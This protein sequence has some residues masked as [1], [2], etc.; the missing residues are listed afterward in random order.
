VILDTS[1]VV[2][3]L[4][5]EHGHESLLEHLAPH[6]APGIGAPT[7]CEAGAVLTTRLGV[8]ARTLL[9][10]FVE[11]AGIVVIPFG[12]EHWP[13]AVDAFRRF[14]KGRHEARLNFGDCLTYATA[15][16]ADE[17]LLALGDDFAKT[18]LELV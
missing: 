15:R 4:L 9:A 14:G 5:R 18:D 17:P 16:L 3:I 2:S 7:L 12:D 8:Q 10:R 11:E 1:A 6:R 13:I